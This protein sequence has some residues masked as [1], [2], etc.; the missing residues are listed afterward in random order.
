[1]KRQIRQSPLQTTPP[2]PPG[3][4]FDSV[5]ITAVGL[6]FNRSAKPKKKAIVVSPH[7]SQKPF[8]K[9][10]STPNTSRRRTTNSGGP[11]PL[12][13]PP[14]LNVHTNGHAYS[15]E[16][17]ELDTTDWH[18]SG[19]GR[20]VGY[21]DLTAIDWVFE[22]ARERQR[23]SNLYS[24]AKGI[25]GYIRRFLDASKIWIVLIA[26]GILTG[27]LAASIDVASDWLADLKTGFCKSGGNSG[28]RFYLNKVFCCWGLDRSWFIPLMMGR[29]GD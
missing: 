16:P 29:L 12:S 25:F 24:S 3:H 21:D 18:S 4:F 17:K 6:T 22:Y 1:M 14:N 19:N 13:I 11:S 20:R 10:P 7:V 23:L 8:H 27:L 5:L 9:P 28:G 15:H 26:T 2:S